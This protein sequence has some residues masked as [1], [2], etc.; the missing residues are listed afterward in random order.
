[1]YG[2]RRAVRLKSI[3][4][5]RSGSQRISPHLSTADQSRDEQRRWNGGAGPLDRIR[6]GERFCPAEFIPIA[7]ETGL[8]VPLG[9][10]V[11]RQ[12]CADARNWPATVKLAVNLSPVQF[13]NRNLVS[14][15]VNALAA[16]RLPAA[17][18]EL[19]ITEAALMQNDESA[20]VSILQ[21]LRASSARGSRSMIS[22]PAIRHSVICAN[23]PLIGSRS[24]SPSSPMRIRTPTA[25][26]SCA[27]LRRLGKPWESRRRPRGSRPSSQLELVQRAGCTEGQGHLI[28][29]ARSAAEALK[30]IAEYRARGDGGLDGGWPARS[31]ARCQTWLCSLPASSIV[32]RRTRH[33]LLQDLADLFHHHVALDHQ[34]IDI[35]RQE[36]TDGVFRRAHDRLAAHVE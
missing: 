11:L 33:I 23:S 13:R 6:S 24:I 9:E 28:G 36:A 21:Q 2:F 26:R 10:W 22:V 15:V 7:E 17:R 3:C 12:A 19:E 27:L 20:V 18:L 4:I 1:M 8:I 16:G 35:G 14:V 34:Q 31:S 30:F 25:Q 5:G 29:G 32:D